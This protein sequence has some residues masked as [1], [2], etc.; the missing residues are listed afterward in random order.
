MS[1]A[2]E[3]LR[4]IFKGSCGLSWM[5]KVGRL[6]EQANGR[7]SREAART[8]SVAPKDI[9]SSGR[10]VENLSY[11]VRVHLFKSCLCTLVL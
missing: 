11:E 8:E 3:Q 5:V 9:V 10:M 6:R 1:R 7:A 4:G 2:A